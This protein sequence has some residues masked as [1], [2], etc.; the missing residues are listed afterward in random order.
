MQD[1][2]TL[3][4]GEEGG[5][6]AYSVNNLGHVVGGGQQHPAR[7]LVAVQPAVAVGPAVLGRDDVGRVAGDQ[8]EAFAPDLVHGFHAFRV[9]PLAVRLARRLEIPLVVTLTGTDA[10]HDLFDPARAPIVL[11]RHARP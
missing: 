4:G 11:G 6:G 7:E 8:V 1:L 3:P 9:G 2:G 10:N 5:A